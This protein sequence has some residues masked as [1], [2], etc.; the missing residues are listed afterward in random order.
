[1]KILVGDYIYKRALTQKEIDRL[2]ALTDEELDD[3]SE[4]DING[5]VEA[6][7]ADTLRL[8]SHVKGLESIFKRIRSRRL[9]TMAEQYG[10]VILQYDTVLARIT[11]AKPSKPYSKI[12]KALLKARPEMQELVDELTTE[13]MAELKPTKKVTRHRIKDEP[14]TWK[15]VKHEKVPLKPFERSSA[16][17][18]MSLRGVERLLDEHLDVMEDLLDELE[19][20]VA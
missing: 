13:A 6:V 4:E 18:R 2:G 10:D 16:P 17:Q 7:S 8:Q 20:A 19:D 12:L 5:V 14:T 9:L 1:M 3:L 15:K 11:T